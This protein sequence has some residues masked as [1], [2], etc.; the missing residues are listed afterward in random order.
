MSRVTIG[1]ISD[2]HG[3]L[4]PEALAALEGCDRLIHAGDVGNPRILD[5]LAR[6][7]PLAA[8]RGNNDTGMWAEM[9]PERLELELAGLRLL[10]IHDAAELTAAPPA[11][12]CDIV[13][14]GHNH[15]PR[16][17]ERDGRLLINPGSAG[18]RR[19][20]L[21]VSVGRLVLGEGRPRT[22]LIGLQVPEA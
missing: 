19:F 7:A 4:R 12:R 18:P 5:T 1:L 20:R 15:R 3:L 16:V 21:P 14:C 17:E 9:L 11:T 22:E 13:I 8:V 6:I 10:V 2:T